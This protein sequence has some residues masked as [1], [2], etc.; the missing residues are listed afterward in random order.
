MNPDSLHVVLVEPRNSGNIGAISRAM[1]NFGFKNLLLLDP[2][3]NH[4]SQTARNRAKHS[5]EILTKAKKTTFN[6]L[7]KFDYVIGTTGKLGSDYNITRTPIQIESL[8]KRLSQVKG[9]KVALIIGRESSGLLNKE[10]ELCDFIVHVPTDKK[11]PIMNIS[12]ATS[13]LLYELSK[14]SHSKRLEDEFQPIGSEEKTR[15]LKIINQAIKNLPFR[16]KDKQETQKKIWKRIIGKSFLTKREA[17]S[18]MGF[19]RKIK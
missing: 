6:K 3:V 11:Y 1:A 10:L 2:K 19:F 14:Q 13:T 15:L 18:L 17:F 4:L 16:T 7:K 9:K 8:A 5:Q 12:H